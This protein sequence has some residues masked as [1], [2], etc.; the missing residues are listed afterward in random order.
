MYVYIHAVCVRVYIYICIYMC[1]YRHR[2][3]TPERE[4]TVLQVRRSEG[5]LSSVL[6]DYVTLS[7]A[8]SPEVATIAV[9]SVPGSCTCCLRD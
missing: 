2:H 9:L 1:M 4:A 6:L 3:S 5:H 8:F 7:A